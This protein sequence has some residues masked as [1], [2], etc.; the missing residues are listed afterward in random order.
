[1]GPVE[2]PQ[3]SG[4]K[5]SVDCS[6]MEWRKDGTSSSLARSVN[7]QVDE[8]EALELPMGHSSDCILVVIAW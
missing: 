2:E 3:N 4:H 8:E 7:A 5:L 1:M 6:G